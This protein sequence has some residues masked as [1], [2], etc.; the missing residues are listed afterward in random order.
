MKIGWR[1]MWLPDVNDADGGK[2][3]EEWRSLPGTV[4]YVHP[5]GRF[6]VVRFDC[7]FS[8]TFCE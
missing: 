4:V 6:Y 7:G 2:K 1:G 8:E 3:K 5:R